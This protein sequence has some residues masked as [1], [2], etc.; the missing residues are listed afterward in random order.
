MSKYLSI[1][2]SHSIRTQYH[3]HASVMG[4]SI[5]TVI[6]KSIWTP[7]RLIVEMELLGLLS[8]CVLKNYKRV[9]YSEDTGK[10]AP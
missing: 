5:F 9:A 10:T 3:Q 4:N 6:P 7:K 8:N 2:I 1:I